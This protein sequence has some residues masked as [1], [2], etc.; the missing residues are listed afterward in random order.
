MTL[1]AAIRRLYQ[2]WLSCKHKPPMFSQYEDLAPRI[3][4]E[5]YC[6]E[7]HGVDVIVSVV[8]IQ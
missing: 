1:A 6:T 2:V 7:C 3:G 4:D 5:M 8:T